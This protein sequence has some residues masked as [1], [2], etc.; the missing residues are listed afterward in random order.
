MMGVSTFYT[1]ASGL[2]STVN[3]GVRWLVFGGNCGDWVSTEIPIVLFLYTLVLVWFCSWREGGGG[4]T[5]DI[6]AFVTVM[7]VLD[8]VPRYS[9]SALCSR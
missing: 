1:G 4:S 7:V 2:F 3:T 9:F 6:G 8:G 5:V